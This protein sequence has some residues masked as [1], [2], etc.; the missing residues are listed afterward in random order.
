[1]TER[2]TCIEEGCERGTRNRNGN[3]CSVHIKKRLRAGLSVE[4]ENICERAKSAWNTIRKN[5]PQ[6]EEE[7]MLSK[8]SWIDEEKGCWRSDL[9][10]S[11]DG[12]ISGQ[13]RNKAFKF[14]RKMYELRNG[15]IPDGLIVRHKCDVPGCFNPDHLELGTKKDNRQD[16]MK[17]NPNAKE[18]MKV[19]KAHAT[20]GTLNFW[21]GMSE[22]EKADFVKRRAER[23]AELRR[24]RLENDSLSV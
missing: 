24:E 20:E 15:P 14:H 12:Y 1:M 22:E 19:A 8:R 21:A 16:F 13:F 3:Y 23:Q 4:D 9:Y 5:G 10:P 17:R 7:Y 18:I 11:G 2:N 6:T